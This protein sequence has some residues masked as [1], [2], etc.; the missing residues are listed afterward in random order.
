MVTYFKNQRALADAIKKVIDDYWSL[1][2][3][4]PKM[5]KTLNH[6]YDNNKDKIIHDGNFTAIIK[7]RLGKK[8]LELLMKVLN[9]ENKNGESSL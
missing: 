7:Q 1:E 6:L 3:P 8:R 9:I 4:E 2:L 5:I